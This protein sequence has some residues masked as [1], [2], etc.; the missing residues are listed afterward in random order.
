MPSM[1]YTLSSTPTFPCQQISPISSVYTLENLDMTWHV[2]VDTN[3]SDSN[4]KERSQDEKKMKKNE[5]KV[6]PLQVGSVPTGGP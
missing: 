2:Q 6:Q 5:E 3:A 4:I 1:P